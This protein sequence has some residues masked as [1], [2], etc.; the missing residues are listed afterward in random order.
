[1]NHHLFAHSLARFVFALLAL[2]VVVSVASADEPAQ[3][4]P[5]SVLIKEWGA[6]L[7]RA[8]K[9][10]VKTDLPDEKL[11]ELGSELTALRLEAISRAGAARPEVQQIRDELATLGAPP[12]EGAPPESPALAS[13]RKAINEKLAV[14]EGAIKEAELIIA[15][16]DRILGDLTRLR[17]TRF[18]E[19]ILTRAESPLSM[20]VW[21]KA[22]P[23]LL[24]D[25]GTARQNVQAWISSE[26]FAQQGPRMARRLSLGLLAAFIL[27]WPLRLWL[28]RRFGYVV[29]AGEPTHGQRLWTAFFTGFIRILLPSAAA[30][31]VY[32][33]MRG[34]GLLSESV[35]NLAW[36]ALIALIFLFFAAAFCRAALAPF[37]P[38]WRIVHINDYGARAISTAVTVL[39]FAFVL[40]RIV[41]ELRVQFE[42]SL[43][44]TIIHKFISGLLITALLLM[45]L[46]RR[47]WTSAETGDEQ[48]LPGPAWQRLRYFL[49]VLV[50]AIPLSALLGYVALSMVLARQLVLTAGLY[51][52]VISL[53]RI[54]AETIEH[55]LSRASA[56]G[57]KLRSSLS[58]TDDGTEMLCFWVTETVGAFIFL[59]GILGFLMLWGAGREDLSV[60]LHNVFFG[61]K[62][63]NITLSLS[64]VFLA[65]VLFAILLT[66]T[67]LLQRALE[68]RI[69]PRTR[70]DA[71]IRHSI[72][73]AV[74]YLGF[75]LAAGVAISTVGIDLSNLAIIAGALSVGIGLGLQNITNNFVSGLILLIERP[76]K[77]GDW[78]V[79]GDQQGYVRKISV[80]ATEIGTFDQA[81]VFIPNSHLIAN[82]VV[83]RTY[84]DKLG[85]V[86][87][88]IGVA[89]GT[90]AK[91]VRELLLEIA[92]SNSDVRRNPGPIVFFKGFGDNALSFELVAVINDVDKVKSVGSDLCFEIDEVFRREGI[93][94]P[95]PQ[96]DVHL[97]LREDQLDRL[98]EALGKRTQQ[99]RR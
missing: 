8:D 87:I 98:V 14:T 16:A 93:Q 23:E 34:S 67:R 75:T 53:R 36:T 95:F 69:F 43:E 66:A 79:V 56:V 30:I 41:D 27:V 24:A 78:V 31:A 44:L 96:R 50:C 39:A 46:R 65:A 18:T 10:L 86:L 19:M 4:R 73:S 72:R 25:V 3:P 1:M 62:V 17:R 7:E 60:W 13:K 47:I 68:H 26:T 76:I 64:D 90:D 37:E 29:L 88:P 20:G 71:G 6:V 54:S 82:A 22:W 83:N 61:F 33:A 42:A 84:A 99:V 80:R 32:L 55:I 63:G 49:G 51:V 57:M 74:G 28:L 59:L 45:L 48:E 92:R 40:D 2:G 9:T 94:I 81:S 58:L 38:A 77:V 91:K 5:L 12:G 70:L 21:Q 89:Y 52:T 11:D 35:Q 85:R 15:R 97:G